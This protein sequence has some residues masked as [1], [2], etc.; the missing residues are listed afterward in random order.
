MSKLKWLPI[1]RNENGSH[2]QMNH[3]DAIKYAES[4]GARLPKAWELLKA[5]EE[6]E[7]EFENEWFWSSSPGSNGYSLLFHGDYGSVFGVRHCHERSVL[8]L[9]S[10]NISIDSVDL[11]KDH[12]I[13]TNSCNG[14]YF[15]VC[16]QCKVEV[17]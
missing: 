4:I 3:S 13:I 6:K 1:V 9:L 10:P 7:I 17:L 5:F 16:K 8:C 11:H 2:K 15:K 12:E 14:I